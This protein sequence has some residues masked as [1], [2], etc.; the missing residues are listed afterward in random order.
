MF[1]FEIKKLLFFLIQG[2][3]TAIAL[4]YFKFRYSH[5]F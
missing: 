5:L 4:I 3:I 2:S 1:I